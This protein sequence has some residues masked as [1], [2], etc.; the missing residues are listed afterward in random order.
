MIYIQKLIFNSNADVTILDSTGL[1]NQYP[2]LKSTFTN[3]TAE[4]KIEQTY[5]NEEAFF[6]SFD[7]CLLNIESWRSILKEET[8]WLANSPS[9]LILKA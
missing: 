3:T 7:L 2:E 1:F 5:S 9:I 6:S 8:S 4:V